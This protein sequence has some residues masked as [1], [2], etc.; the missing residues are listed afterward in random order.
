MCCLLNLLTIL[1]TVASAERSF[2]NL[3]LIKTYF[4]TTMS[5]ELATS[6]IDNEYL[7]A[8]K[9]NDLIEELICFKKCKEK[10]FSFNRSC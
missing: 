7:D 10:L 3:K 8:L 5:I 9:H 2:S 4:R 1:V 6:L